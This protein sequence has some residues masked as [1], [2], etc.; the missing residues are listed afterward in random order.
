MGDV[1]GFSRRLLRPRGMDNYQFY[2]FNAYAEAKFDV[3]PNQFFDALIDTANDS[4]LLSF[5]AAF[6]DAPET[7][8]PYRHGFGANNSTR[9]PN[10]RDDDRVG[11]SPVD[12][13]DDS[14]DAVDDAAAAG[15]RHGAPPDPA[16]DA[17]YDSDGFAYAF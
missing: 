6:A 3:S 2:D 8:K 15:S 7:L 9:V 5:I 4:P 10:A 11:E 12:A 17:N 1:D 14:P 16:D 13:N